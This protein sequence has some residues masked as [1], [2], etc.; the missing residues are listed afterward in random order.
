[1]PDAPLRRNV[2]N[3]AIAGVLAE[4][5]PANPIESQAANVTRGARFQEVR[6]QVFN[7]AATS[8]GLNAEIS[9]VDAV[10]K[11]LMDQLSNV[12]ER[13][14][15]PSCPNLCVPM[16]LSITQRLRGRQQLSERRCEGPRGRVVPQRRAPAM[17]G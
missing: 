16:M 11:T 7:R 6:K 1:V 17:R 4:Q 8:A 14:Q 15:A 5:R 12:P 2:A 10:G 13:A 3:G 9:D